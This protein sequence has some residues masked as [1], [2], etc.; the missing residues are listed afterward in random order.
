MAIAFEGDDLVRIYVGD[1]LAVLRTLPA[2]SYYTCVTSPPYYRLRNYQHRDQIGLEKTPDE[3]IGKLLE[4]FSAVGRVLRD[5]GTLWLNIGDCYAGSKSKDLLM[6]PSR[7]AL[8]LQ[9][10]G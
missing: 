2:K 5:D 1:C 7:V 6:M 4:V 8:A 9:A 3:Y 10:N